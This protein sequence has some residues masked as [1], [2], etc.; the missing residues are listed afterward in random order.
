MVEPAEFGEPHPASATKFGPITL[1]SENKCQ[2]D[3]VISRS[4]PVAMERHE[5]QRKGP[6]EF[7]IGANTSSP[8]TPPWTRPSRA[9]TTRSGRPRGHRTTSSTPRST[10]RRR[11][12]AT[13]PPR[14]R[15]RLL[16]ARQPAAFVCK[17]APA[18]GPLCGTSLCSS[19]NMWSNVTP[20]GGRRKA[21]TK[22]P[23]QY[24]NM[25]LCRACLWTD[26]PNMLT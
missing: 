23:Q 20:K 12:T 3:W 1:G 17:N 24:P 26:A 5:V 7:K 2:N 15:P 10:C 16:P 18:C 19:L 21:A 6:P 22:H 8:A 4:R 25:T 11:E 13:T 9:P 14:R